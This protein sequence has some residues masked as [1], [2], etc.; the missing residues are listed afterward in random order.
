[1]I[2]DYKKF[3]QEKNRLGHAVNGMMLG[4]KAPTIEP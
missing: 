4:S 1:M 3:S 2:G